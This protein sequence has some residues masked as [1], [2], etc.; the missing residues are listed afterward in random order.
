MCYRKG[1]GEIWM[2]M[3]VGETPTQD[4]HPQFRFGSGHSRTSL[5][6]LRLKFRIEDDGAAFFSPGCA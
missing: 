4:F 1:E 5:A 6:F 3:A 2:L